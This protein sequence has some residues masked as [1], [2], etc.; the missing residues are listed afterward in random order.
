MTT[1]HANNN[2][3]VQ[4]EVDLYL[5]EFDDPDDTCNPK[6]GTRRRRWYI[7]LSLAFLLFTATWASFFSAADIGAMQSQFQIDKVM[8]T[9]GVS[10]FVF[11]SY[12]TD[13]LYCGKELLNKILSGPRHRVD[14]LR[15]HL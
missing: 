6:N 7:T 1:I 4:D 8:A 5:V 11:V 10:N 9:L 2:A 12:L 3:Q 14:S 15:V 13:Y